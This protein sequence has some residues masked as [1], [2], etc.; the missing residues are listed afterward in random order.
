MDRDGSVASNRQTMHFTHI[1]CDRE[2]PP[3]SLICVSWPRI[4]F[5]LL[6]A[7]SPHMRHVLS[8][9][10]NSTNTSPSR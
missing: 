7:G 2:N 6:P 1:H 3:N 5:N 10:C 8:N 9:T 4:T